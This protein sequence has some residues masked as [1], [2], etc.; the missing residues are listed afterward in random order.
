MIFSFM[1][2][3]S[4]IFDVK[5]MAEILGVTTGGY[6][7]WVKRGRKKTRAERHESTASAIKRIHKKS[8]K[9][10]GVPRIFK[11]L[12]ES[13]IKISRK[14]VALLMRELGIAGK[15]GR[16]KKVKTTDS[17]HN[18]PISPNLLKQNFTVDKPNKVW[19]SDITYL[20]TLTGWVYLC[21][22]LDLFNREVIGWSAADNM[23]TSLV[24][25]AFD[26]A[27][28]YKRPP[29]GVI[30]HSDRGSQ[31]ASHAFRKKLENNKFFQSMSKKGDCYDNAVAESFFGT[32]KTEE[33]EDKIYYDLEDARLNMFD[34]IE[35][36][37]NTERMHSF[38]GYTSP[39]K[40]LDR[41]IA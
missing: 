20:A 37:Y 32:L 23:K 31:Y 3:N 29:N 6:Y 26:K 30:F 13:G 1:A 33:V 9:T 16:K 39:R 2:E 38:L 22:I 28:I 12:R 21:V 4:Q 27:I 8:R 17:D 24:I 15:S 35:T 34:Y 25:D 5:K 11:A 19:V 36:F 40:Y 7:K 14:T 41:N 18:L 10:Y